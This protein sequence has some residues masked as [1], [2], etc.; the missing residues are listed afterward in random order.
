MFVGRVVKQCLED[1]ITKLLIIIIV[2]NRYLFTHASKMIAKGWIYSSINNNTIVYKKFSDNAGMFIYSTFEMI[3]CEKCNKPLVKEKNKQTKRHITCEVKSMTYEQMIKEIYDKKNLNAQ[4]KE[5]LKLAEYNQQI[6]RLQSEIEQT[7]KEVE[8][9]R[10]INIHYP[11]HSLNGRIGARF[12]K[13]EQIR[14]KIK[15]MR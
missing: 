12:K 2:M 10:K 15:A 5:N 13:I 14:N 3:T 6:E 7:R 4:D 8:R 9:V 1:A 11:V